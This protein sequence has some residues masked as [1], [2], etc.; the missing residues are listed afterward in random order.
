MCNPSKDQAIILDS[1]EGVPVQDYLLAISTVVDKSDIRYISKISHGR[2][3]IYLSSKEIADK[4]TDNN[5]K[6]TIGNHKLEIRPLMSKSKR[7]ILSNVCPIIPSTIIEEELLKHGIK[8]TSQITYTRAAASLP[9]FTH[10]LSF[11]RQMY[12]SPEDELKMPASLPII[13]DGTNYWIY[14]SSEKLIC[15]NCKQEGHLAKH[16]RNF[17][18]KTH[19]KENAQVLSAM[20]I[21][22]NTTNPTQDVTTTG[23]ELIQSTIKNAEIQQIS[24][25]NIFKRPLSIATTTSS[26]ANESKNQ[27]EDSKIKHRTKKIKKTKEEVNS[28]SVEDITKQLETAREFITSNSEKYQLDLENIAKFIY[29]THGKGN[30]IEIAE[31]YTNSI[32]NLNEMLTGIYPLATDSKLKRRITRIKKFLGKIPSNVEMTTDDTLSEISSTDENNL[33]I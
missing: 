3:C 16:C 25:S 24:P 1:L 13:Y 17:E 9:G 5:V 33:D 12:L 7:I 32:T 31:R 11:R 29:E 19:D 26:G 30:I 20:Q 14:L 15:F 28:T 23:T 2:V 18:D 22:P 27:N 21:I 4:L 8:P 10:V 6:I